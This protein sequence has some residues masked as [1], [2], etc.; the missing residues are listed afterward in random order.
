MPSLSA[1]RH[2]PY[3]PHGPRTWPELLAADRA[4]A[5]ARTIG[6]A[7]LVADRAV[8]IARTIGVAVLV[9]DRAVAVARTIGVAV[10]VADRAVAIARTIGVAVLAV[11]ARVC[12][13][14]AAGSEGR[15]ADDQRPDQCQDRAQQ[16]DAPNVVFHRRTSLA[17]MDM[18]RQPPGARL[19][20]STCR[21]V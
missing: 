12:L 6:V 8:A 16:Q 4:V 9:A 11:R 10:L 15:R 7:V 1:S 13:T 19:P 3:G 14:A 20:A 17:E 5:V 2:F 21:V 18:T